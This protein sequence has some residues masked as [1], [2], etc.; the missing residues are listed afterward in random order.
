MKWSFVWLCFCALS[1]SS[2]IDIHAKKD[3]N[4]V[5][6]TCSTWGRYHF[7]TFD[8]DVYQFPG[9]CEYKLAYDCHESSKDFSVHM[10][11]EEHNGNPT[12]RYLVVTISELTFYLMKSNVTENDV[13]VEIPYNK[14]GVQIQRNA[15][16]II[17][18]SKVGILLVWNGDDAVMVELDRDYANHTCG[19]CGDFNG[20]P[21]NNEFIHEGREITPIEFGNKQKVHRPNDKCEDPPEEEDAKTLPK[22]CKNYQK[23]CDK[24]LHSE[25]WKA[26]SK[27][28]N[29]EPYIQ[30]CARDMCDCFNSTS[31]FCK[32]STFS[33]FSR[34]CSHA[35][36]N[37]PNWRTANFCGDINIFHASSFHIMLQTSFGLQIQIQHVPLMQV[38]VTLDQSYKA[39]TRG[40]C[41]NYN[42]IQKDDMMSS[43]EI[44]EGTAETFCNS[45]TATA[46]CKDI[47]KRPDDPCSVS[48][49]NEKYAKHWCA[50]LLSRK[51]TFT[52]CHSEVDPEMYHKRCMYATCTCAKTEDC[53]CA[54]LSSYARACASKGVNLTGWRDNVCNKHAKTCPK[55]QIFS[56]EHQRCQMTCKSL[57]S[58][59]QSCSS[60]FLPVDGCS[61]REGFY[62][63]EKGICVLVSKCPCYHND[64]YIQPGKSINIKDEHCIYNNSYNHYTNHNHSIYTNSYNTNCIYDYN[65]NADHNHRI[66]NNTNRIYDYNHSIYNNSNTNTN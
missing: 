22:S 15:V 23:T 47:E 19:L 4:H 48:D 43:Q 54:V 20:V 8:G 26:C 56:Y 37:P 30:A 58:N 50:L 1:F 46:T 5:R 6:N 33:E 40:L 10:K 3:R 66:Y 24:M 29:P 7:K 55:S 44:V 14:A 2:V 17:F 9:M 21:V 32:C 12:I 28:I 62:L 57:G 27:V 39:K 31:D 65:H 45:W 18:Q 34:Q 16:Y 60:D 11:R 42:M 59:Q 13:S 25:S 61:C 35:G 52:K 41:G 38:Y 64:A 63:N 36:A 53:L 49:E 51:S